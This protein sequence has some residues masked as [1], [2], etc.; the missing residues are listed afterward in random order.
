MGLRRLTPRHVVPVAAA[1]NNRRI[2]DDKEA[3]TA[4]RSSLNERFRDLIL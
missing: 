4:A 2:C 1:D 3:N